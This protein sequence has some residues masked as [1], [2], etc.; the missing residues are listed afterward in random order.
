MTNFLLIDCTGKHK[1]CRKRRY[2]LQ[3]LLFEFPNCGGFTNLDEKIYAMTVYR[4][5][6]R[7]TLHWELFLHTV[8]HKSI[9]I[10]QV[11]DGYRVLYGAGYIPRSGMV[12]ET[13]IMCSPRTFGDIFKPMLQIALLKGPWRG[14][15]NASWR[16]RSL[17]AN[18]CHDFVVEFMIGFGMSAS[19]IFPYELRNA[20]TRVR[21]PLI[22]E[23]LDKYLLSTG[24]KWLEWHY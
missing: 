20:V 16:A 14:P 8:N 24:F 2:T 9:K 19:Q 6:D 4:D 18:T 7:K 21:P 5:D 23:Y 22:T 3:E 17:F 15:V 13:L 12:A 1:N 10:D 11:Q